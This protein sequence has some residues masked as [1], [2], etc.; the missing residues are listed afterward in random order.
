MSRILYVYERELTTVSMMKDTFSQLSEQGIMDADFIE[1]K[2][3]RRSDIDGHEIIVLIRPDNILSPAIA[4]ETGKSGRLV[5]VFCDDDL[6]LVKPMMP[7]RRWGLK[8]TLCYADGIW[9]GSGFICDRYQS[10]TKSHR[11]VV[12]DTIVY[13]EQIHTPANSVCQ[14]EEREKI[15]IVYAGTAAHK[16]MFHRYILPVMPKLAEMYGN[17]ISFT[18]VG[19]R[20]DVSEYENRMEIHYVDAMPLAA[21]RKF[22]EDQEFDIGIAPLQENEFTKCKYFNKYIEY[23][24]SGVMGIYSRIIPYLGAV[25]DHETGILAENTKEGWFSAM[26]EAIEDEKLRRDC[27]AKAQADLRENYSEKRILDKLFRDVPELKSYEKRLE[28]CGSFLFAKMVYFLMRPCDW[29]YLFFYYLIREKP[30]EFLE[31]FQKHFKKYK[32]S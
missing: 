2:R 4:K 25:R 8:K 1:G 24:L 20:P 9:S 31:R 27:L 15:K 7:W 5:L 17:R 6:L 19:V 29:I 23:S 16:A 11:R 22:M 21:Y 12:T 28:R 14:G 26:K 13:K 10:L 3:V 32:E 30:H 18:F